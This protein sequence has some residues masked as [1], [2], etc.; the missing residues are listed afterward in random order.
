MY[1]VLVHEKDDN[2]CS[3]AVTTSSN[4]RGKIK[5]FIFIFLSASVDTA[6]PP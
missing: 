3:D 5:V 4:K 1:L 2:H 6:V